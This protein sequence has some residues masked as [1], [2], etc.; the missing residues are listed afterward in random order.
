M[1]PK[2]RLHCPLRTLSLAGPLLARRSSC[3]NK[4]S[5]PIRNILGPKKLCLSLRAIHIQR[6]FGFL[7]Q[8]PLLVLLLLLLFLHSVVLGVDT[9]YRGRVLHGK[10]NVLL[11][12]YLL[13]V[14]AFAIF[15]WDSPTF[16][17]FSGARSVRLGE[18]LLLYC[19]SRLRCLLCGYYIAGFG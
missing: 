18:G 16:F 3:S 10:E 19:L 12:C 2:D 14:P 1:I 9:P 13:L 15:S 8:K 7:F 5:N 17:G 6:L 11:F 4:Q